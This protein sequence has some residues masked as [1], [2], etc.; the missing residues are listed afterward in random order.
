M[1]QEVMRTDQLKESIKGKD[2]NEALGFKKINKT[3]RYYN[4]ITKCWY[5]NNNNKWCNNSCCSNYTK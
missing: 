1:V 3:G 2:I 5:S 4:N